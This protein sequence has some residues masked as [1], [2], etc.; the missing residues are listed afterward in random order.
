MG[1][2]L[3]EEDRVA[4]VSWEA[5][6]REEQDAEELKRKNVLSQV[7]RLASKRVF[8]EIQVELADC[9]NTFDYQIAEVPV[10]KEQDDGA[11]WGKHFV[12]QTTNGGYSGDDYAGTISIPLKDGR[13]FQFGYTM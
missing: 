6:L 5:L 12:N 2:E 13:Y 3:S 8:K 9:S 7:E 10:G 4:M 1:F 11:S